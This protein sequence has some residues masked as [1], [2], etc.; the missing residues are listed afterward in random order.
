[1]L[2]YLKSVGLPVN[3][4]SKKI[5]S[6]EDMVSYHHT[7]ETN[8][9]HIDYEIDGSVIKVNN[10]QKRERLGL[11]SRSPRWA[12]AAKFKAKQAES[13]I[14][15]IDLQAVSYTHLTLPTKA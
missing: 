15:G 13:Q 7:L 12:I 6:S 3:P 14:I 5:T 9:T 10:Y 11:R 2:E 4:L 8:R 1:M